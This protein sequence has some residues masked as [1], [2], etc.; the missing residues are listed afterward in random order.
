MCY[1]AWINRKK[2]E[3]EKLLPEPGEVS[4]EKCF[5]PQEQL[6]VIRGHTLK[7]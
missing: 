5:I 2:Q 6:K 1:S 7:E 3:S 4:I